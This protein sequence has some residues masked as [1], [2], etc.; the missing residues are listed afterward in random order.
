LACH[1][2]SEIN[3][4][5]EWYT[6]TYR[7]HWDELDKEARIVLCDAEQLENN[8]A[9]SSCNIIIDYI[10]VMKASFNDK[11]YIDIMLEVTNLSRLLKDS[12]DAQMRALARV[13]GTLDCST[14]NPKQSAAK[15]EQKNV[16][17]SSRG[18]LSALFRRRNNT[19]H[20]GDSAL[21]HGL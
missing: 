11:N 21:R 2:V 1:S 3:L 7:R 15:P 17:S 12:F 5:K 6:T 20:P 4:Q 13:S 8:T 16:V 19:V 9:I 18:C 14:N 10:A